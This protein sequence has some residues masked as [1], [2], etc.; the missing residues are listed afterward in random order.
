MGFLNSAG[1]RRFRPEKMQKVNLFETD[2]M[3]CDIYCLEPGQAQ[4]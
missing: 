3:F 2:Q 4:A 1:S